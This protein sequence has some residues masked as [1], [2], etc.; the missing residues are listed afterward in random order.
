MTAEEINFQG[1]AL[2]T[3][4]LL[5]TWRAEWEALYKKLLPDYT[6]LQTAL[7]QVDEKAQLRGGLGSAGY[8][9]A[10]DLAEV[11]ALDAAMTVLNGIKA[12]YMDGEHP[13]LATLA[14][15]TRSSLD[16]MRGLPQV[17]ALEELHKQALPLAAALA[18]ELVTADDLLALHDATAA[19]KPLLGTPRQQT[20]AGSLLREDAVLH[21]GDARKALHR[22]DVRV[23]NL[24]GQLPDLVKEY[25][26]LREIVDAGHG[27]GAALPGLPPKA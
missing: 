1:M 3:L 27:H 17:A 13:G 2:N 23:P 8:T 25:F 5:T 20:V 15:H 19:F 21:L 16:E 11:K 12:L 14:R 18:E 22:L 26:R 10:K 6:A 9:Q 4:G 7:G 24:G